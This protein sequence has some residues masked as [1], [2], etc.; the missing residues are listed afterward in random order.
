M[1]CMLTAVLVSLVAGT[2]AA[3]SP[4]VAYDRFVAGDCDGAVA[5][6]EDHGIAADRPVD[7][8][9]LGAALCCAEARFRPGDGLAYLEAARG[10]ID[11]ATDRWIRQKTIACTSAWHDRLS[12]GT[13]HRQAF[14]SVSIEYSGK[15]LHSSEC[16]D[17]NISPLFAADPGAGPKAYRAAP[18]PNT[19]AFE[20]PAALL[21]E[22][23]GLR[24]SG[25]K[26]ALCP[27]FIAASASQ[28]P[29]AVC[30][31]AERFADFLATTFEL[32]P[33]PVWT[34]L[35]H[36]DS[37]KALVA[38]MRSSDL[39]DCSSALGYFD[40]RRNRIEYAAPPGYFGTFDHELTHVFLH[41]GAPQLPR[42]FEEGLA[43]LYENAEIRDGQYCGIENPWRS[44]RVAS[45]VWA[46]SDVVSR[47]VDI[48][49][50]PVVEFEMHPAA[51][52]VAREIL[53]EV[54]DRGD[55]LGL[56]QRVNAQSW[57]PDASTVSVD[58]WMGSMPPG[59]EIS[60]W[61]EAI[62]DS[63]AS[64]GELCR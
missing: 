45:S 64:R 17:E 53:R 16:S 40:W 58:E 43:A 39:T 44:E 34:L 62:K 54:Q 25:H 47:A 46:S 57:G 9:L 31:A 7:K 12:A 51:A 1:R 56:Y 10:A 21:A 6:F 11:A 5:A 2:A 4:G 28:N 18:D 61:I 33:P 3:Q 32:S 26:I 63:L 41:W 13:A 59:S 48:V 60:G 38:S 36:H 55:L 22:L 8:A 15:I 19:G 37:H 24:A 29:R 23:E 35:V 30:G 50:M 52:S 42:W 27:P 14:L 20:P 49:Q